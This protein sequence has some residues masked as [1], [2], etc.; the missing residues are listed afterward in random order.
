MSFMQGV[1]LQMD[2]FGLGQNLN[3]P[4]QFSKSWYIF[5][6]ELHRGHRTKLIFERDSGRSSS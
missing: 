2:L 4:L 5:S 3:L 6:D 1:F